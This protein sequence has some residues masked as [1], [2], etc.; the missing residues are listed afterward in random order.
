MKYLYINLL[1]LTITSCV[2][3]PEDI[4]YE[5]LFEAKINNVEIGNATILANNT[6]RYLIQM[7]TLEGV[8]IKNNKIATI[9]VSD[10][11]VIPLNNLSSTASTPI[12][13]AVIDGSLSFYLM[14][15]RKAKT[16]ATLTVTVEGITQSFIFNIVPSEP[17]LIELATTN[18]NP[19]V[20]NPVEVTAYLK[21][22]NQAENFVSNDLQIVFSVTPL[23][24][25]ISMI[26]T[27]PNFSLSTNSEALGVIA[28]TTLSNTNQ[29]IGTIQVTANY[30]KS[31]GT[32]IPSNTL[33]INYIP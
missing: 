12:S 33:L 16:G 26:Q 17:D 9:S 15:G 24:P 21:K 29:T 2:K 14:A 31:D 8:E 3:D 23:N 6:T 5:N 19:H 30:L 27:P 20:G 11:I 22:N 28:K 7:K 13:V 10:G 32:T 4:T 18:L 1:L 25:L